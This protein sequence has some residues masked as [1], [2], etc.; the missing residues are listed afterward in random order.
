MK[1]QFSIIIPVYNTPI[2]KLERC[3]DS[4]INQSFT[5]F[6]LIIVD[7]GSKEDYVQLLKKT[8]NRKNDSR[9]ILIRKKNEGSSVAR[10]YGIETANGKYIGFVDSD[11]VLLPFALQESK[12]TIEKYN[13]DIVL[14]YIQHYIDD[15]RI[16]PIRWNLD[17][18][19]EI[20]YLNTPSEINEFTNHILGFNSKIYNIKNGNIADSPCARFCRADIVKKS[21][22]SAEGYCD[23]DTVWN[24]TLFPKCKS[25]AIVKNVWYLYMLNVFSKT[26]RFRENSLFELKYRCKQEYDLVDT[27]FPE[28]KKGVYIR[29]WRLTAVLGRTFLYHPSNKLNVFKKLS[30]FRDFVQT[31]VYQEM[32]KN[33]TFSDDISILKRIIKNSNKFFLQHRLYFLSYLMWMVFVKRSI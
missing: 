32:L 6:E 26:R 13:P 9:L 4:V 27:F 1:P 33:I 10:N 20:M 31:P 12:N 7:D 17:E 8:V 2:D 15:G 3:L 25:F 5:D 23:D 28:C 18:N 11:D 16:I 24:L 22:F 30:V 19:V 29:I 21:L 14:G